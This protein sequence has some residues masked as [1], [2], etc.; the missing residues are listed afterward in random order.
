M[1]PYFQPIPVRSAPI[2]PIDDS[3]FL[4]F[5]G[6]PFLA[7][8][9]GGLLGGALAFG[10]RPFYPPYPPPAPYPPAPFPCYGNPCQPYYY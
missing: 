6:V 10:P 7:G 1:Y 2:G 9:A 8:I 3:R 5:F 4:P